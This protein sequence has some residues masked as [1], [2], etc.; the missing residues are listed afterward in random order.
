MN[1]LPI[2]AFGPDAR[3]HH[4]GLAVRK[5][6]EARLGPLDSKVDPVQ[7]VRVAF[8]TLGNCLVELLEPAAPESPVS[9]SLAKGNRLLHLCFEVPNL[10]QALSA[11]RLNGFKV[12]HPPV[13]A[14]A[15]DGRHIAWL[16]HLTWGV[17]ELL[18]A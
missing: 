11:A 3:F 14:I 7:K 9:N 4:V 2:E 5:L 15:F 8:V 13:Q 1:D 17:V 18:E 10:E 16:F 12:I 6:E